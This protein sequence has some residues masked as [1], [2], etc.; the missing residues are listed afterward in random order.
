MATTMQAAPVPRASQTRN[1]A[2][3]ATRNSFKVVLDLR[4]GTLTKQEVEFLHGLLHDGSEEEISLASKRLND[5]TLFASKSGSQDEEDAKDEKLPKVPSG[6]GMTFS[7]GSASKETGSARRRQSLHLRKTSTVHGQIWKAHQNGLAVSVQASRRSIFQKEGTISHLALAN[8]IKAARQAAPSAQSSVSTLD[9][10]S[11][12]DL[13]DSDSD[14]EEKTD[15]SKPKQRPSLGG[16]TLSMAKLRDLRGM[17][18][19]NNRRGSLHSMRSSLTSLR[20]SA[21]STRRGSNLSIGTAS[22]TNSSTPLRSNVASLRRSSMERRRPSLQKKGSQRRVPVAMIPEGNEQNSPKSDRRLCRDFPTDDQEDKEE[23]KMNDEEMAQQQ[24]EPWQT[25]QVRRTSATF[26]GEGMEVDFFHINNSAEPSETCEDDDDEEE[27]VDELKSVPSTAQKKAMD[28]HAINMR[29]ASV[30]IYKG[31]GMEIADWDLQEDLEEQRR[32]SLDNFRHSTHHTS[33]SEHRALED[34]PAQQ[35]VKS[36]SFDELQSLDRLEKFPPLKRGRTMLQRSYSEDELS[37]VLAVHMHKRA[38][39]RSDAT[40]AT[41]ESDDEIFGEFEYDAWDEEISKEMGNAP[42]RILGTSADDVDSHPHVLSP[43]LMESLQQFFPFAKTSDNFW[44][45]YSMVRDGA[46]M[47]TL[48]QHARGAKYSILAIETVDGEVMGSFTNEPWR[49]TWSYFGGGES[50][51][52]R[53]KQSRKSKCHSIIDMAYHESEI[54]V[55]PYTGENHCVQF[56]TSRKIAVGGGSPD[57]NKASIESL[58]EEGKGGDEETR[59]HDWGYGIALQDDLLHGS[60]SPCVTFGSPSLSKL[61]SDGSLFEI[62]NV[63]LWTLTPCWSEAEA[64]KLEL[65][66]LFLEQQSFNSANQSNED[67]NKVFG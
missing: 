12:C 33:I 51:L 22:T 23:K 59:E 29:R 63:E 26:S 44:M 21:S 34:Q 58:P 6:I 25:L 7:F 5:T 11:D 67:L 31:E 27:G 38:K 55:Y 57:K 53:M 14:D 36:A 60:S 15:A 39:R 52:W 32:E 9:F 64:E 19:R 49:K 30:N 8:G 3:A 28:F 4:A 47:H 20:S 37:S 54:D 17:A 56:C 18:Y 13:D 61:H 45:K 48:L 10:T 50:F 42:F 43:P 66:K 24:E 35:I 65:G 40:A 1:A 16:G 62:I 41:E 2:S 46:S